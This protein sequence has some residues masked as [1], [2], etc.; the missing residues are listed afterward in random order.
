MCVCDDDEEEDIAFLS[1]A[2]AVARQFPRVMFMVDHCGLPY[3]RDA[4][5]M[6]LWRSGE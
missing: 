5:T 1:R 6:K 3:E 4:V 2:A